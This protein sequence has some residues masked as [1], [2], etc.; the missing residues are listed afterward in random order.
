MHITHSHAWQNANKLNILFGCQLPYTWSAYANNLH[1]PI[2]RPVPLPP[3]DRPFAFIY[4]FTVIKYLKSWIKHEF[5][6]AASQPAPDTPH[7][8]VPP[9]SPPG[10]AP[11]K[12]RAQPIRTHSCRQSPFKWKNHTSEKKSMHLIECTIWQRTN[13]MGKPSPLPAKNKNRR[14]KSGAVHNVIAIGPDSMYSVYCCFYFSHFFCCCL[15]VV[16]VVTLAVASIHAR[17]SLSRF[18]LPTMALRS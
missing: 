3:S 9:L 12:Y 4:E 10:S 17:M 14:L 2:G 7:F 5:Y 1:I 13:S 8:D 6:I 15:D 11:H 16:V 18:T